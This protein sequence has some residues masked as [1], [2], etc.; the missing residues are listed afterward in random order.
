MSVAE[1]CSQINSSLRFSL[2]TLDRVMG[3]TSSIII[4]EPGISTC[5]QYRYVTTFRK[6]VPIYH[7]LTSISVVLAEAH[8]LQWHPRYSRV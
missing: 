2:L 8:N 6:P 7:G 5:H 1:G 4:T 3:P